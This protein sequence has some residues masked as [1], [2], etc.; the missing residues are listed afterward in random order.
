M[1]NEQNKKLLTNTV[2][3]FI[4]SV[5]LSASMLLCL[6]TENV[7]TKVMIV[8][9][10][11]DTANGFVTT[12]LDFPTMCYISIGIPVVSLVCFAVISA[13]DRNKKNKKIH[14]KN[15]ISVQCKK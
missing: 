2:R 13:I 5:L 6:V 7:I 8:V 4:A 11:L 10:G 1:M 9:F 15:N 3:L 14:Q 12:A